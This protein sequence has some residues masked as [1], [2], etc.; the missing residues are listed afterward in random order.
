MINILMMVLMVNKNSAK[1]E[2]K[3]WQTKEWNTA[4]SLVQMNIC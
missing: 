3:E 2:K 1:K 4:A